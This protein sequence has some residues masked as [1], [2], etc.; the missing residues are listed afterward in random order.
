PYPYDEEP[1][2]GL[3]QEDVDGDGRI[4]QMRIPDPNGP[5]KRATEDP[6]LLVRRDPTEVGGQYY[7]LLPE[8]RLENYD[9]VLITIQPRKERLDLNRNFPAEWRAEFEQPGAGPYPTSE[10]EVRNLVHFIANHPN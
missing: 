3:A 8:G 7:R 9:G 10:P 5:W 6:R 1:I 2:E 4:L